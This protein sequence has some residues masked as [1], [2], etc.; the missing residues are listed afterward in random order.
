MGSQGKAMIVG[1][2]IA[3]LTEE[4]WAN[5]GQDHGN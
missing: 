3:E 5:I 1:M 4:I 2:V